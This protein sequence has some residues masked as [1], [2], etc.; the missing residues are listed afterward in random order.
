M[1]TASMKY[2]LIAVLGAWGLLSGTALAQGGSLTPDKLE[3]TGDYEPNLSELEKPSM[4][5]PEIGRAHV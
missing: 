5:T 3:I 1:K 2:A 4:E